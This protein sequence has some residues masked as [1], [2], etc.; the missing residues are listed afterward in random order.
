MGVLEQHRSG[1]LLVAGLIALGLALAGVSLWWHVRHSG[2]AA[3][4]ARPIPGEQIH[5]AV[6][7]L[8]TTTTVGLARTATR[9]LRDAGID[10]VYYGSD[11]GAAADS[12]EV[13]VRR[14]AGNGASTVVRALGVGRVRALPDSSRLVDLTVRLGRDFAARLAA[15]HP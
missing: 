2:S 10:V 6:E 4:A 15:G 8:N 12:T 9:L 1:R 13:L 11:T 5:L 7:V 3:V 14:G